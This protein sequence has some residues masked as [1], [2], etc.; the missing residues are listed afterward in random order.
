MRDEPGPACAWTTTERG[1]RRGRIS[2]HSYLVE[3]LP[4]RRRAAPQAKEEEAMR[5]IS[6]LLG[7]ALLLGIVLG[8]PS[9][10]QSQTCTCAEEQTECSSYCQS[11]LCRKAISRC[12]PSDPCDATCTCGLCAP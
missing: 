9:A 8:T 5:R 6:L 4:R 2:A 10:V 3:S 1:W 11:I 7:A 12:S